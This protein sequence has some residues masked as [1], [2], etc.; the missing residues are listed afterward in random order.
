MS[1]TSP[2]SGASGGS[3]LRLLY[4]LTFIF[5]GAQGN[6][7][8]LWLRESGWTATEIGWLDGCRYATVIVMPL[9]WGR[10]IDRRGDAVGVLRW[11]A[12]A[13]ALAFIPIVLSVDFWVVLASL[14]LW[15]LFRVGQI[16]AL[17]ALTLSHVKRQGGTYGR[18][19]SWGSAGFII[20][21][22]LLG[23]LV[24]LIALD[25]IPI[26]LA[27]MLALT[28][29]AVWCVPG[30]DVEARVSEGSLDALK[31]LLSKPELRALYVSAFLSRLT[32]HGLYGFLPHHLKDLGVDDWAL[33]LYWSVGVLS[34]ILL[35]RNTG[36]LFRGRSTRRVLLFCFTV[37]AAQFALM[38][39]ITSPTLLLG[40]MSLH[41]ITFGL[42]Y[43]ASMEFLGAKA[44]EHERGTAQALF[45]IMAFGF[46]GTISAVSAG[47][48]FEAGSGPLMFGVAAGWSLVVVLVTALTFKGEASIR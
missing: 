3:G 34:E 18:F 44:E 16:P 32:Q 39:I 30:E 7:F 41:G 33:P 12:L 15:A 8:P 37:A 35:I 48:L 22:L 45:Q 46:G 25:I 47:Y 2:A 1:Q 4:L 5:I 9:F 28:L 6:F 29:V 10:M 36:R 26:A 20:G 19:R 23:W 38:A 17:D 40:V 27:L 24:E 11:L 21:G 43:V 13:C 14:T 42:W 31:R